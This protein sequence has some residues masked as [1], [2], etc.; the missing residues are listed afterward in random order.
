MRKLILNSLLLSILLS[1][2]SCASNDNN[3]DQDYYEGEPEKSAEQTKQ[4]SLYN[5]PILQEISKRNDKTYN[6]SKIMEDY[7]ENEI[8]ADKMYKKKDLFVYGKISDIGVGF[9]N[10]LYVD[11][12]GDKVFGGFTCYFEDSYKEK[13]AELNVDEIITIYGHC[14][15]LTMTDCIITENL[16]DLQSKIKE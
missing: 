8:R 10:N 7:A 6:A 5:A 16:E 9:F 1:F 11:L 12:D 13:L 2:Y 15:G 3:D 4:D 14:K